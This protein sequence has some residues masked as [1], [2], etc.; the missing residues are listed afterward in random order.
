[1]YNILFFKTESQRR[2][3]HVKK[4]DMKNHKKVENIDCT[5][6]QILNISEIAKINCGTRKNLL[7]RTRGTT[8]L[9]ALLNT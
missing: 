9:F 4:R 6:I 2:E 3:V 8:S 5:Y 7:S 1:M